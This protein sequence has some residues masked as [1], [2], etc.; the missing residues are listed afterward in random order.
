MSHRQLGENKKAGHDNLTELN[1]GQLACPPQLE[2]FRGAVGVFQ[3]LQ[4]LVGG[5]HYTC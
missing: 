4:L 2:R 1:G 3:R 5:E